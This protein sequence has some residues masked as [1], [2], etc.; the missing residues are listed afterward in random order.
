LGQ[1][2]ETWL[3]HARSTV[4]P[5]TY[6]RYAL[7]VCKNIIPALGGVVL[8]K[9]RPEQIAK[10]LAGVQ[11]RD[12][13][14]ALSGQTRLHIYRVL[15]RALKQA[16]RWKHLSSNPLDALDSP[17]VEKE[18]RDTY[19]LPQTMAMLELARSRRVFVPALLATMCG[20]RRG[21]VCA[22]RW[23]SVNLETAQASIAHSLE[24]T[25][26]GKMRFKRPKSGKARTIALPDF[27]IEELR[28]W[29]KRQAEELLRLGVRQS[30]D[31]LICAREDGE[32]L[33][34][35][36]LTHAWDQFV[37]DKASA[38]DHLR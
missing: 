8:T 18:P 2:L 4:A 16:V 9:L 12:G 24:E 29:R 13:K 15:K 37:A 23:G 32:P 35:R 21:E 28:E 3:E 10:A 34:P 25:N 26:D 20:L 27:V 38:P 1:F 14:G 19:D 33:R 31:T 22:L 11:R 17:R 5:N 30:G 7:L 6:D 36:S